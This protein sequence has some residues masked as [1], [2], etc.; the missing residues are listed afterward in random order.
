MAAIGCRERMLCSGTDYE[1]WLHVSVALARGWQDG[2]SLLASCDP[3]VSVVL[4][5]HHV[6]LVVFL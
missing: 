3:A 2:S 5:L 4:D 6:V 1:A